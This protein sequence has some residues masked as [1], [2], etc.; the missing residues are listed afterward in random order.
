MPLIIFSGLPSS[1]KSTRAS[2]L[3]ELLELKISQLNNSNQGTYLNDRVI[4]H[5]DESLGIIKEQYRESLTEKSLRGL[6][7]SAVKRDLSKN[8]I[9]ILDS[10][11]YI[12]GFRY[13][14]HCEAK[15]L[16]TSI[17]IV[18]IISSKD[19][20]LK[21]NSKRLSNDQW[22]ET[23][24]K[25]LCMRFEEPDGNSRWDSPL[26]P[27]AFDDENF[28]INNIDNLNSS[29]NKIWDSIINS[30]LKKSNIVTLLK[31]ATQTNYLNELDKLTQSVLIKINESINLNIM[32]RIKIED[33]L[34][35]EINENYSIAKLQRIR[36]S[37]INL[38][39][40]RSLDIDRIIPLFVE[41]L[42]TN[43]NRE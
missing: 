2:K 18:Y 38:N 15:N 33:D 5:S 6:Q 24:L 1:G 21:F 35:F 11:A 25:Q 37:F 12:K 4:L 36:R 8:Q 17:C 28:Q 26:I 9:V 30:K 31:P 13:Q 32:G 3:K 23:L 40:L 42:S 16:G 41:Y 27:I 34:F 43:L 7:M 14:L 29:F 10:P 19:Q 20:C 22:D 39:K